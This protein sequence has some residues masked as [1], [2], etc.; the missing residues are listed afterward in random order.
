MRSKRVLAIGLIGVLLLVFNGFAAPAVWAFTVGHRTEAQIVDCTRGTKQRTCEGVW[1]TADGDLRRDTV[2]SG[3]GGRVGEQVAIRI[4]PFGEAYRDI[5]AGWGNRVFFAVVVDVSV[6]GSLLFMALM[7]LRARR[8]AVEFADAAAGD[9]VLWR[10][11]EHTVTDRS[12][13]RVWSAQRVGRRLDAVRA[14]DGG[15]AYPVHS[16]EGAL[17][18]DHPAGGSVG[19]IQVRRDGGKRL[20]FTVFDG[21]DVPFAVIANVSVLDSRWAV[22]STARVRCAEFVVAPGHH[23][24]VF[25]PT[26]PAL[27][28]PLMAAFLLDCRRM[29][30]EGTPG[31]FQRRR[32]VSTPSDSPRQ[33]GPRHAGGANRVTQSIWS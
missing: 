33:P 16:S 15:A 10:V 27:L 23:R 14:A 21:D 24:I 32:V 29:L 9:E 30:L 3:S 25:A 18:M 19:G 8:R 26:A 31:P 17:R 28:S 4:G 13:K 2:R 5:V 11:D 6:V 12:G 1:T 7:S 20:S 22:T